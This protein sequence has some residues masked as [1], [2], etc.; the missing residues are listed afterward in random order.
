M[1]ESTLRRV[2]FP[3]PFRPMMPTTS[4]T[5]TSK[6][7]SLRAQN[8]S[9]GR[10]VGRALNGI[11]GKAPE[12]GDDGFSC[13]LV[14]RASVSEPILLTQTA[15]SDRESGHAE[16]LFCHSPRPPLVKHAGAVSPDGFDSAFWIE[17]DIEKMKADEPDKARVS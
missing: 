12:D 6:V 1:R 15:H 8:R 9:A 3:A 13:R 14:R 11:R 10:G 4:P 17:D 16:S 2:L 7:T 5:V